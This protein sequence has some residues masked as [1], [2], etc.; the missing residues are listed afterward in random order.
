M[1]LSL[2]GRSLDIAADDLFIPFSL[3]LSLRLIWLAVSIV[4]LQSLTATPGCL[5]HNATLYVIAHLALSTL[6]IPIE[7]LICVFSLSGTLRD[8]GTRRFCK[9]RSVKW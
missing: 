8:L 2:F 3:I 1:R 9:V 7:S 4:A 5:L 6:N